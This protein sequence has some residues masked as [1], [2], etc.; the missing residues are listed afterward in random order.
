VTGPEYYQEAG[1]LIAA[2]R[3]EGSDGYIRNADRVRGY[4]ADAQG[5]RDPCAGRR[6][7]A[8]TLPS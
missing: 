2:A 6:H 8:G 5:A 7:G 3:E 1:R 4:L